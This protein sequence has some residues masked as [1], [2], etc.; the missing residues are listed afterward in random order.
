M[1]DGRPEVDDFEHI[2]FEIAEIVIDSCRPAATV[3]AFP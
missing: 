2:E 1:F 3:V